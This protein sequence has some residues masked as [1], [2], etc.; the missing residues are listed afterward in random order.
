MAATRTSETRLSDE[1]VAKVMGLIKGSDSV[2]LKLTVPTDEH[3]ATI[4]RLPLD[5]VN[6]QPRQVFFI[7]ASRAASCSALAAGAAVGVFSVVTFGSPLRVRRR[8][9]RTERRRATRDR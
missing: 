9:A 8:S 4:A 6:T 7:A 5:P 3:R 1:D 2:E